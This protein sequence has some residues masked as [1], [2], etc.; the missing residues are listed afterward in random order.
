M[1]YARVAH[2]IPLLSVPTHNALKQTRA[3][4]FGPARPTD[5]SCILLG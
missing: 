3:R 5:P 4:P 1:I 2:E